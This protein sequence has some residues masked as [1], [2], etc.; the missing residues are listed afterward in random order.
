MEM[1]FAV[2]VFVL[3]VFLLFIERIDNTMIALAGAVLL[4]VTGILTWEEAIHAIDFETLAL[5]LGLMFTVAIAE[6]SG[7]F[8]WLNTKIA[9]LS[10]GSPIAVFLLFT[11]VTAITSTFL[12]NVTVV[13]L[14]IPLAIALAKNLNMNAKLL[15]VAIAT[16]SNIGGTLTLIGDPPNTLIGVR[17]GLSFISFI[18]NLWIPVLI[19][20]VF[21]MGY[22]MLIYR[23]SFQSIKGN[24]TQ[25]FMG[26]LAVRRIALAFKQKGMQPYVVVVSLI[27]LIATMIGFVV[28]PFIGV[29]VGVVGLSSG[30]VLALLTIGRVPFKAAMQ[31]VEWDSLLFFVGLFVQVGALEKVGFLSVITEQIARFSDNYALMLLMI[32]WVIGLASTVINN[33]PFVALMIPVIFELQEKMTGQPDLDL[34]WWA[35]ALG[36]CLGGNGT[37][38]GSSAGYIAVELAKKHGVNISF[39]EFAKMG[40]PITTITL[41]V[42]SL[43]L[44]GRLYLF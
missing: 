25:L 28:Q 12:N 29:S 32:V 27:V 22:M 23:H 44:M 6:K 24:L 18:Q 9:T 17:A 13:I 19:M 15:V 16:F 20:S 3:C 8:S 39:G 38:I 34:M 11:G 21:S 41:T 14:I 33:I 2:G 42:S 30:I 1:A 43:Y 7:I 40:M 35:L 37:I 26:T 4:I 5:L 10:G 36:A 31:E